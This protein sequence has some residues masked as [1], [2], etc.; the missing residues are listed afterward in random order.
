MAKMKVKNSI[1]G[2][3][4]NSVKKHWKRNAVVVV[5]L[6]VAFL[7]FR[8]A[9][10]LPAGVETYTVDRQDLSTGFS[11]N[12]QVKAKKS[13]DLRFFSPG[14]I[15]WINVS[16]G[17]KVKAWQGVA[18]LDTV[19]LNALYQQSLNN[20]RNYQAAADS[21]LDSV[22]SHS[23][24]ETFADR[25][26]RTSAEV[27]RDN[28]YD[29]ILAAKDNLKNAVLVSPIAGVVV[30]TSDIIPGMNLS[31]SDLPTKFVRITD[32]NSLYF[33]ADVDEVDYSKVAMG[34][35]A[36]VTID[37]YPDKSCD[38]KVSY[39]GQDGQKTSGGVV[40]IPTEIT[41]NN[42]DLNLVSQLNGQANFISNKVDNVLV[43]PKK[44]IVIQ[45]GEN[46][47]WKQVGA[48]AKDKQLVAVKLGSSSSTDVE[49]TE[50]LSEGD[51][52][53]YLP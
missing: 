32:L 43:I 37:A 2:R 11:A 22:Q 27:N 39:V 46:F 36:T 51:T 15:A 29:A 24:D 13:V 28:A 23:S 34:Q 44:Y 49:V 48:S 40:S 10:S 6:L 9:T 35:D 53:I 38:G 7:I 20:Y 16:K 31:S 25:A 41:L 4:L 45:N 8:K 42:C 21:T 1:L 18:G 47:V 50:G 14:K 52:I 19:S 33:E 17:D 3:T 5:V 12:G 26:T 30:E